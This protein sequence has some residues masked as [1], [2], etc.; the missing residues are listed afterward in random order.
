VR[1]FLRETSLSIRKAATV[2]EAVAASK[3]TDLVIAEYSLGEDTAELLCTELKGA[4][5]G[6]PLLVVTSATDKSERTRIA[7]TPADGFLAKPIQQESL[8]RALGEFLLLG[9]AE[10][11]VEESQPPAPNVLEHALRELRRHAPSLKDAANCG[12]AAAARELCRHIARAADDAGLSVIARDAQSLADSGGRLV[13]DTLTT[14]R[15]A[16]EAALE[17]A[18]KAA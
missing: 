11:P 18:K 8:L 16:I 9:R 2:A 17:G 13:P 14:L 12:D 1:H 6:T 7:D 3:G 5:R 4:N 10:A 15:T